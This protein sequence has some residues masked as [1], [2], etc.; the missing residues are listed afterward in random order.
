M[1]PVASHTRW[2]T[3]AVGTCFNKVVTG[4]GSEVLAGV[5]R[6]S[7]LVWMCSTHACPGLDSEFSRGRRGWTSLAQKTISCR[8]SIR[9]C[10]SALI[11]KEVAVGLF[12][13]A[14][15]PQT[16][17]GERS[18]RAGCRSGWCQAPLQMQT[19][20]GVVGSWDACGWRA[21]S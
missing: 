8:H 17:S 13:L 11:G 6:A 15:D 1:F 19:L 9:G 12:I 3:G 5:P 20:V 21:G 10:A 4:G 14:V 18:W 2:L 16:A 7:T